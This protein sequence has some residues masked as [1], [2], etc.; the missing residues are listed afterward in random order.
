MRLNVRETFRLVP[1][2]LCGVLLATAAAAHGGVV[3]DPNGPA[4]KQ[5]SADLDRARQQGSG[6]GGSAGVPGSTAKAPLFG[7][8]VTPKGPSGGAGGGGAGGSGKDSGG[9]VSGSSVSGSPSI[10]PSGGGSNTLEIA[11]I[12]LAVVLCGGLIALA[13]RRGPFGRATG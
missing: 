13:L 11:G 8:G 12:S 7:A 9:S 2:A 10:D 3:V 4:S 5:Y 6:T 1:I